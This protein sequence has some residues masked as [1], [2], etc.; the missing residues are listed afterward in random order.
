MQTYEETNWKKARMT[1]KGQ[2]KFIK[3][4]KRLGREGKIREHMLVG[5]KNS[6]GFGKQNM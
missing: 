1:T 4:K 3:K 5:C 2:E 6:K